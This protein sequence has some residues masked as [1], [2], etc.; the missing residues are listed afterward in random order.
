LLRGQ[1]LLTLLS[2]RLLDTTISWKGDPRFVALANQEHVRQASGERLVGSVLD[3]DNVERT[4]MSFTRGDDTDATQVVTTSHHDQV[5]R[6]ELDV[7]LDLVGGEVEADGVVDL[8]VW[9]W[10]TNGA[11]IVSDDH[12]HALGANEHLLDLA[13]LVL[14]L[15]LGDTVNAKSTLNVIDKSEELV[16]L[17]NGD[18]IHEASWVQKVSADLV[19]D[20]DE[21]LRANLG[22]LLVSQSVLETVSQEDNHRQALTELVRAWARTWGENAAQLVEHPVL[23]R[24]KTLQVFP[25]TAVTHFVTSVLC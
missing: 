2:N 18:D 7:L 1:A 20:L 19:V 25:S 17:L 11:T 23:W 16:S 10:V 12:W 13:Q 4:W 14:G 6:V 5:A 15:L 3:V 8:D 22:S 9:V 24:R 21:T